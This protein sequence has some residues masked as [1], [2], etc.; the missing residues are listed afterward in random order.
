MTSNLF[1]K[2]PAL[3]ENKPNPYERF[4]LTQNPFP[5]KPSVSIGTPD[6]RQNG[7]IYIEELRANEQRKFEE[8]LI[9]TP[10]RPQVRQIAF[11]MD[12]ATRRGRGIGKTA[13]LY[14]QRRR[15]MSDLGNAVSNGAQVLFASYVLPEPNGMYR[16]FWKFCQLVVEALADEENPVISTA[17]WRLRAYSGCISEEIL[18]DI[19]SMPAETIG[20]DQ[21]LTNR[22][23]S[24]MFEL[25]NTIK[26]QLLAQ[27]ITEYFADGLVNHGH[28]A[29]KFRTDF[30]SRLS[31]NTWRRDGSRILFDD[32]VKLFH[33]CGFNRGL[34]LVDE[35]ERV[36]QPQ[37]TDERRAFTDSVRY[38]LVDGQCENA[39]LSFLSF[40]F[41]IHPYVQELLTPHWEAS[42]LDRF[43]ALS[44]DLAPDYTVYL[45]P[46]NQFSA[47]PLAL[48]YLSASRMPG[49]TDEDLRP[50]T[51][52]A[53]N[54]ALLKSGRVPGRFLTLLNNAIE[55]AVTESWQTIDVR[56]IQTTLQMKAPA[57][58]AEQDA[59]EA[60][61]P[62]SVQLS[63]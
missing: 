1:R 37:N 33:L 24:V 11:L 6:P 25:N 9:V 34:I 60:L 7:S 43:A 29:R 32:L 21:W 14:H 52:E 54:E 61:P 55:R 57:E 18:N 62:P 5:T 47:K 28:N 30:L 35:M 45:E 22:G 2:A 4:G 36:V 27:G 16:K 39:R 26:N 42:G 8:L 40:V 17:L 44:R 20:N 15:I 23:V 58:P 59:L 51:V 19:G 41:T 10:D 48:A 13:F 53:L 3:S 49:M 31:D 46:L 38:F 56:Q 50:F 63:E 12:Y